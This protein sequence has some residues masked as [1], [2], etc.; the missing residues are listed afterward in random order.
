[1]QR[2]AADDDV[3]GRQLSENPDGRGIDPDFLGRLAQR[4]LAQRLA[5]VGRAAGQ[6]NLP[7]VPGEP[8]RPDGE[9]DGDVVRTRVDEQESRGGA[10][11]G[12]KVSGA[13]T[14]SGRRRRELQLGLDAGE[15]LGQADAQRALEM[16]QW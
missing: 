2:E 7:G 13:P 9:R 1:M 15:R 12:R 8:A 10:R 11:I 6:A 3:H 14:G 4:R 5:F 16:T